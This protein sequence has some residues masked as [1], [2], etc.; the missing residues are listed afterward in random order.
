M[1]EISLLLMIL[2]NIW[3]YS[4]THD[5][6]YDKVSKIPFRKT[7]LVLGTS[8]KMMSGKANPYFIERMNAV[9]ALYHY[10]KIKKIIVSGEESKNYSEPRAMKNF[11]IFNGGIPESVIVEDIEGFNTQR[12]IIRCK[13]IFY[14][15]NITIVSQ[16][17]HNLRA[18]F[19]ARNEGMNALGFDAQDIDKNESFYRNHFRE[20]LA[21]VR[22][23]FY[24]IFDISPEAK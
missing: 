5:R 7:A 11:L 10:G 12:S 19:I 17:F 1:G 8:P 21:K 2:A 13:Y 24:Y 15:N 6:T 22:A 9:A 18:L 3:V 16:G 20:F 4:L 14:E 23:V